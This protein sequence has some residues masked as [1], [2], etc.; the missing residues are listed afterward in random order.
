[1]GASEADKTLFVGN[2]DPR[3]SEEILFELFLQ[4][5]PATKVKIPKDKDGKPKQFAF[6]N[7]KHEE[8][9]P[10]GMRL[11]NGIKLFG[12]PLKIQYRSGSKHLPQ[13]SGNASFSPQRNDN[14]GTPNTT[15]PT[16]SSRYDDNGDVLKYSGNLSP[17]TNFQ[18]SYSSPE[19]LQRKAV[20]NTFLYSPYSY[21]SGAQIP[22][23]NFSRSTS[24]GSQ[25]SATNNC[26][27]S[28]QLSPHQ[29]E[30]G[31][32]QHNRF[33]S[34]HPYLNEY[35]HTREPYYRRNSEEYYHEEQ[36]LESRR[37]EQRKGSGW[38]SRQ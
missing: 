14:G 31:H 23:S 15:H 21:G 22:Q 26:Q 20:L 8:S 30:A 4:A 11:L 35:Q 17:A 36:N 7:F 1:M 9:V 25:M 2:L 33:S 18:R 27:N 32:G 5:G 13:D 24:P 16:N 6:V 19:N 34:S 3:T 37:R 10:Y 29:Y 12:R 28:S 38:H